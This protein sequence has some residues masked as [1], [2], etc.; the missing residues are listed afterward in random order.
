MPPL[1]VDKFEKL[2]ASGDLPSPRGVALAII[3]L[4]RRADVSINELARVIGGDPAFVGRLIKAAN[5][6]VSGSRRTVVSVNEA[7]MVCGMPAVRTMALGFSLLS[8]Y[9]SGGCRAFDYNGFWASSLLLGVSLQFFAQRTR[10]AAADELFSLGLLLRVGELGLATVYPDD[11]ARVLERIESEP[12]VNLLDAEKAVF[13]I[14]HVELGAA[15]LADWGLPQVFIDAASHYSRPAPD[16]CAPGSRAQRIALVVILAHAFA[17][18]CFAPEATRA[19]RYR[20]LVVAGEAVG[21]DADMVVDDGEKIVAQWR[22]WGALLK[23]DLPASFPLGGVCE[24]GESQPSTVGVASQPGMRVSTPSA[25]PQ[26]DVRLVLVVETDPDERQRM[27]TYAQRLGLEAIPVEN[28]P[29]ALDRALEVN[30]QIICMGVRKPQ[31]L[32]MIRA[33]RSTRMGKPM[34]VIL[35][36]QGMGGEALLQAFDAGADDV[37]VGPLPDR[38][39]AAR[40]QSAVRVVGLQE[41]LLQEREELRRFAAELAVSNRRLKEAAMTDSLTGFRNRRYANERLEQAWLAS[42]RDGRPLSCLV[43]DFDGLKTIND[44]HGHAAGDAALVAAAE[45]LAAQLRRQEIV[46]RVGGDE[47][48][49]ICPGACL[50]EAISAAERLRA[51]VAQRTVEAGGQRLP[52]SLSVGVAERDAT[53]VDADALVRLADRGAYLAKAQGRNRVVAVQALAGASAGVSQV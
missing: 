38:I 16:Q 6:L 24:T 9:R 47:F 12:A 44:R 31:Q 43:M 25:P 52:L 26:K 8:D 1:Q 13:A 18:L 20:E 46:C 5:G 10:V 48:L 28:E 34:Y 4:T 11:Y 22:D 27:V 32:E 14:S 29:Q 40:L 53:T 7:L 23:F 45:A 36:V 21:I 2:R 30:P 51:A 37:L 15:M 50:K 49:V 42:S 39:L 41:E 33:L 35:I 17:D 3:G 19:A